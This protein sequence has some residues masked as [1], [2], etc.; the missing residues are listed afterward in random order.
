M[1]EPEPININTIIDDLFDAQWQDTLLTEPF[2]F[3]I[4]IEPGSVEDNP[5]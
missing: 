4:A 2:D 5:Q 1:T 3:A